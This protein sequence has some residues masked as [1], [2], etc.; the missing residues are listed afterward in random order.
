MGQVLDGP[1][2]ISGFSACH[3]SIYVIGGVSWYQLNCLGQI[4]L[5]AI[6]IS[7]GKK[8]VAA[9]FINVFVGWIDRERA[10]MEVLTSIKRAGADLIITYS[11]IE[12]ASILTK[13]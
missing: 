2:E 11:A 4:G 10:M 5:G 12:A 7:E 1:F 8:V 3:S 9:G 6:Q 13:G